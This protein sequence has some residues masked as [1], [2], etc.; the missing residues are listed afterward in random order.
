MRDLRINV[1]IHFPVPVDSVG[2]GS[3][4]TCFSLNLRETHAQRMKF[5]YSDPLM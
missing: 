4:D 2:L 5:D 1:A 3:R